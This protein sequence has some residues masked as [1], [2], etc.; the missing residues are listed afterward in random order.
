MCGAMPTAGTGS[1]KCALQ[2]RY[3]TQPYVSP[4]QDDSDPRQDTRDSSAAHR[5]L[6]AGT[7]TC[8]AH[9]PPPRCRTHAVPVLRTYAPPAPAGETHP[10]LSDSKTGQ[11]LLTPVDSR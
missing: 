6:D 4:R 7:W 11:A 3:T 10:G 2:V 1:G 9:V 5:T 8:P